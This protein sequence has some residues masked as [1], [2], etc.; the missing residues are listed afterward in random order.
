MPGAVLLLVVILSATG[1]AESSKSGRL[2]GDSCWCFQSVSAGRVTGAA[3]GSAPVRLPLG[4]LRVCTRLP[5]QSTCVAVENTSTVPSDVVSPVN[6]SSPPAA[7]AERRRWVP[8]TST[9][10]D[11]VS[12][13]QN[14]AAVCL[15]ASSSNNGC[16]PSSTSTRVSPPWV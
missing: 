13:R 3:T 15:S 1:H 6:V 7:R 2:S 11:A 10:P 8:R 14:V 9:G 16:L 4:V 5:F 12:C